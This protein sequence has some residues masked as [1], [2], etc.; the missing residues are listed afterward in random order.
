MRA[1]Y[2]FN[3]ILTR[4]L[5]VGSCI[6]YRIRISLVEENTNFSVENKY[7]NHYPYTTIIWQFQAIVIISRNIL[8]LCDVSLFSL[9]M[10]PYFQL[11]CRLRF[12][13]SNWKDLN[14]HSQK[15]SLRPEIFQWSLASMKNTITKYHVLCKLFQFL[16]SFI[17]YEIKLWPICEV[18]IHIHIISS[19]KNLKGQKSLCKAMKMKLYWFPMKSSKEKKGKKVD[20]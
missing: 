7:L 20:Y 3:R 5:R 10:T 2:I 19:R 9:F 8:R 6:A 11:I 12:R 13:H 15:T 18:N 4:C 17:K 16:C 14:M 1:N